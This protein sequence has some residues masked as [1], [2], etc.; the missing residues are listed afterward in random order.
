[1]TREEKQKQWRLNN[2]D[3]I[4]TI[5]SK[6]YQKNK[7]TILLKNKV[8]KKKNW[9]NMLIGLREKRKNDPIYRLKQVTRCAIYKSLTGKGFIKSERSHKIL[10][11]SIEDFKEYIESKFETWMN[12][13]NYGKYNGIE[14]FGWDL[15]HIIPISSGSTE[16]DILDL[17]HYTNFQPLCSKVN[18]F[19]KSDKYFQ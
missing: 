7:D 1:M 14:N 17:N 18:R 16:Q 9:D 19:I 15:D 13:E 5:R 11:C 12:W 8:I 6:Y 2:K 4:K 10:G 3:R